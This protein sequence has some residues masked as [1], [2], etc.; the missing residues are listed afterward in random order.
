MRSIDWFQLCLFVAALALIT[1]PMGL[2]LVQVLDVKGR[3]WFDPILRPL[4]KITY[5]LMGVNAEREQ[6]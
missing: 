6:D 4:E 5:R 3:T 2:Y 1:K